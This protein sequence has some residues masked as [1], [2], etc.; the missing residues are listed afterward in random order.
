[1]KNKTATTG[2]RAMFYAIKNC[3]VSAVYG[4]TDKGTGWRPVCKGVYLGDSTYLTE[5]SAITA[6]NRHLKIMGERVRAADLQLAQE[7]D[8]Q[9]KQ[10]VEAKVKTET[11]K[12]HPII[13]VTRGTG[14]SYIA[15]TGGKNASCS[16]SAK[17][18]AER[19]CQKVWPG[20]S[21]ELLDV[22]GEAEKIKGV[23]LFQA[24]GI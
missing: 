7:M 11:V 6:G 19:V 24:S 8:Q 4:N 17:V 18:A 23:L 1:M 5:A 15:R 3:R 12:K 14:N 13:R 2:E 20:I 16:Y 10:I 9:V 22:T 21:V